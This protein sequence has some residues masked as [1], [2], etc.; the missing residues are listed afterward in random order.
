M[1]EVVAFNLTLSAAMVGVHLS[2]VVAG[3]LTLLAD[4]N[5]YLWDVQ[6][7]TFCQQWSYHSLAT[8][9]MKVTRTYPLVAMHGE[10]HKQGSEYRYASIKCKNKSY[11][12]WSYL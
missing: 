3:S 6:Y 12:R 5:I 8:S 4:F 9:A 1:S 2:E 11:L 10:I 7:F